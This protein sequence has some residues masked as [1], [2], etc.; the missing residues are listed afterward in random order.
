MHE[1]YPEVVANEE[2]PDDYK[3]R[4]VETAERQMLLGAYRL[5]KI[6][7]MVLSDDNT[8]LAEEC[9]CNE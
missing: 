1:V 6:V 9:R 2:L 3:Q 7:D 5:A 8:L 4:E